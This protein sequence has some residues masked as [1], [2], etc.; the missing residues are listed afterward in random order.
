LLALDPF[1]PG[2]IIQVCL[3]CGDKV[4]GGQHAADV[5]VVGGERAE[6]DAQ[7]FIRF[8]RAAGRR[9]ERK[10]NG[11]QQREAERVRGRTWTGPV[12]LGIIHGRPL[13]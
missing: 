13:S 10:E 3:Q 12:Q 1:D 4:A 6:G 9:A 11:E 2:Q 5:A 7:G 8:S